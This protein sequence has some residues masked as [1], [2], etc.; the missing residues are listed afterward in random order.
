M[1]STEAPWKKNTPKRRSQRVRLPIRV[2]VSGIRPSG[3]S[4]SEEVYTV[5]INAHGALIVA[6]EPLHVGQLLTV[7]HLISKDEQMCRV[8]Q[9][10]T[11]E[12]GSPE[13]A[14]EFLQPAPRFWRVAFPPDDWTAQSPE[15]KQIT[16]P[17]T[18]LKTGSGS[19]TP[20]LKPSSAASQTLSRTPQ[21]KKLPWK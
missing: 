4:F 1:S 3:H 21:P 7:R 10:E 15:A 14:I 8:I 6:A 13:V 19:P 18:P 5:V 16:A 20:L 9:I 12:A 2:L 17:P 11:A